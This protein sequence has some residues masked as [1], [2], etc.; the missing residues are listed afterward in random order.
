MSPAR[1]T[2]T[3]PAADGTP[4]PRRA[5]A[6][7]L[8]AAG[9][10]RRA[11]LKYCSVLTGI[12]ALP[13][14]FAPRIAEALTADDRPALV[15]LEFQ[16]CAGDTESF[17]RARDPSVAE[18]IFDVLS[19]DYHETLM[20]AAGSQAEEAREAA[21]E[22]GGHILVVEG[23]VPLGAGGV[24]CTIGGRTAEQIL[25]ASAQNAAAVINVGTCSAYGGLP[26]A[27]P[28]PT[29][30]VGVED[31][32][33]GV[34]VLNL[35]GCPMNVDNLTAAVAHYLTFKELPARDD[36]GRPLFAYGDR[37]HDICP[38]RGYFDAGQFAVE[39]GD[40]GHRKGWCLYRLGCKGPRTFHNCPVIQWNGTTNW[41]IGAGHG[42]LGCSEPDFWDE[43]SPFYR[44]LP[45]Q[46][47][48]GADANTE[49]NGLVAVGASAAPF[50][51]QRVGKVVQRRIATRPPAAAEPEP[52]SP[53]AAECTEWATPAPAGSSDGRTPTK[54][55]AP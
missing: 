42:C 45:R 24:Y 10:E 36:L 17:L 47:G 15:W 35:P 41:P 51:A 43:L 40:E 22:Q 48:A 9:I 2:D 5:L 1:A 38:R 46:A 33:E 50:A 23:S 8:Q 18:I 53:R 16:D 6:D 55:A 4:R 39:W 54:G 19:V 14:A 44:R 32:I 26:A 25:K 49:K 37:I 27:A 7:R 20:A 21:V 28:N 11:F 3:E 52:P 12:L 30:A 34:P 13:P 31:V 29:G